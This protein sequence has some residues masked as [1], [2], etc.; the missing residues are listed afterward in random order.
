M[1][2]ETKNLFIRVDAGIQIGDGHFS[3][4]LTLANNL[5]KN[6]KQVI[7]ISNQLPKHFFE[8]IKRK[9]FKICKIN[10]Y[11]HIQEERFRII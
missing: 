7:F 1:N 5:K 4:C 8:K 2:T 3:R 10:G 11:S 6:F 9:N